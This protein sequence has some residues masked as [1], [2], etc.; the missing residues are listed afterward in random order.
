MYICTLP[1]STIVNSMSNV[2]FLE[3]KQIIL[4]LHTHN[5]NYMGVYKYNMGGWVGGGLRLPYVY[6]KRLGTTD[7]VER[8]LLS[9]H[10]KILI[11]IQPLH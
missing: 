5:N 2:H 8:K 9:V 10:W 6:K 3:T 11:N 1:Q 4:L 7:I